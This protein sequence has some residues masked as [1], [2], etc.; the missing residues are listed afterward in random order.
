MRDDFTMGELNILGRMPM[1]SDVSPW[2]E[3]TFYEESTRTFADTM[4]VVQELIQDTNYHLAQAQVEVNL[5]KKT[6]RYSDD[7]PYPGFHVL[8]TILKQ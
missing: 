3:D 1:D 7:D 6:A 5:A 4:Q 8:L 2:W